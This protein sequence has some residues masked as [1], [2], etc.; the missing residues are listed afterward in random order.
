MPKYDILGEIDYNL[1]ESVDIY[2]TFNYLD[3]TSCLKLFI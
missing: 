2:L 1:Y 3:P